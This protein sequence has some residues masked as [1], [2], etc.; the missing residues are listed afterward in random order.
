MKII[1]LGTYK[2]GFT[3]YKVKGKGTGKGKCEA[4]VEITDSREIEKI[5]ELKIPPAYENVTILNNKK[6]IAYGYDSKNRK[7][8]LYHPSFVATQN[9]KKYNKISASIKFF[10]K[11]K[12]KVSE[13]LN[14]N[15][16]GN[17]KTMAIAVIISLILSCGFRIGNKKYEKDNNSVGLTTL[18]YKHL[19]FK[20]NK[21]IIDFIGKKG[22]R[23]V[24]EC[25]NK[26]IYD[27]LYHKHATAMSNAKDIQDIKDTYIFNY[28]G[29]EASE[30]SER[31]ERSEANKVI[32][33]SDVNEYLRVI[34]DPYSIIITTKDL[35][36]WNAN[37][38]F[39]TYYRKLQKLRKRTS[40]RREATDGKTDAADAA[41]AKKDVEAAATA[42]AEAKTAKEV[43]KDIKKAIEM[44]AEKLHNSYSICKKS[45]I[46]PK[47]IDELLLKN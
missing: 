10:S 44:V 32:S 37:M 19:A 40:K 22:V 24:A 47:I 9:I 34:S 23:N 25:D 26:R 39:L 41:D 33:S 31:S 11:L 13:D 7:Q 38:L 20:D 42:S 16:G 4:K 27:Y 6:I 12:K 14:G 43:E 15:G 17:E 29:G 1:R 18:K 30:R 8:V 2:T 46:D 28:E 45:Y 21:V 36:T 35:R 3:Y 5:K